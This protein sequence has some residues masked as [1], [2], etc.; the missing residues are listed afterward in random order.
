MYT[1][2]CPTCS[3]M[4]CTHSAP[5]ASF[6]IFCPNCHYIFPTLTNVLTA[7]SAST[8]PVN[9]SPDI[10][11]SSPSPQPSHKTC[12]LKTCEIVHVNLAFSEYDYCR[13]HKIEVDKKA[14]NPDTKKEEEEWP[15][16]MW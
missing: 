10:K 7:P 12:D 14:L 13:T 11:L 15:P 1:Y 8:Q 6:T 3:Y 16:S 5:A 9:W 4:H 2:K